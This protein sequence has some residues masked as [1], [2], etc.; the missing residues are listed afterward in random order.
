MKKFLLFLFI[1]CSAKL[2]SQSWIASPVVKRFIENKS[3][4]YGK[5]KLAASQIL[6]G[7]EL[8]GTQIYFSKNGLTYRFDK[9]E[10]KNKNEREK[11][12]EKKFR[13]PQEWEDHEKEER[14]VKIETDLVHM[15]WEN[16][17]PNV[18]VVAEER[19]HDYFSYTVKGRNINYVSGYEKI[20]YKDLY[21]NID[22][23][24]VFHQKG[25]IKYSLILHPGADVSQVKMKY[26]DANGIKTD[27]GGNIHLK[28][29]CG[30]IIEH[31][32][33][34]FFADDKK[35]IASSYSIKN[36]VVSFVLNPKSQILNPKSDLII[37]PWSQTPTI[38][39]S[40]AVQE[41]ERDGA[42]NVYIIG[43]ETPMRLLKYNS[44]GVLQ[45][46]YN[47]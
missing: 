14:A 8:S 4:F 23:E 33:F 32:P 43:G 36:N 7:T 18:Q 2:F 44:A 11:E 26:T 22:V 40:N 45:W 12:Y 46:T 34:T 21:P 30:D 37:D 17:N 35:E 16:S 25:G 6:F 10:W 39:S 1:I 31:A 13:T 19:V 29:I 41:C 5:D 38:P 20:V 27:A 47:T 24:Y 42:G 15:Q 28:T 3:Q 9:R